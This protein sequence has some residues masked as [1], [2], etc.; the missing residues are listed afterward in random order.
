M[1]VATTLWV[2]G[3]NA[4]SESGLKEVNEQFLIG[5]LLLCIGTVFFIAREA[6]IIR[7]VNEGLPVEE[8]EE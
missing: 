1:V 7:R 6:L 3:L 4:V 8:D 5:I 2:L